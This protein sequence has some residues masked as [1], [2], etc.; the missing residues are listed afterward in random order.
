MGDQASPTMVA[1][2]LVNARGYLPAALGYQYVQVPYLALMA[3]AL[4]AE[5]AVEV[6][7]PSW[8]FLYHL[9]ISVI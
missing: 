7:V 5:L 3:L 6:V 9:K 8:A 2:S 4:T 1:I